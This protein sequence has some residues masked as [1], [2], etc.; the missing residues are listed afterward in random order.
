MRVRGRSTYCLRAQICLVICCGG[1]TKYLRCSGRMF[2]HLKTIEP[3]SSFRVLTTHFLPPGAFQRGRGAQQVRTFKD[4]K[5]TQGWAVGRRQRTVATQKRSFSGLRV[6]A[7]AVVWLAF[8]T[9]SSRGL[10]GSRFEA[11]K[12]CVDGIFSQKSSVSFFFGGGGTCKNLL[13]CHVGM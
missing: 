10:S 11:A 7:R 2:H 12:L 1:S 13:L 8:C 3:A 4:S 9:A 5:G 6:L